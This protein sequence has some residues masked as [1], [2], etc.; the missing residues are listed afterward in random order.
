VRLQVIEPA[1]E[2]ILVDRLI[3]EQM[4]SAARRYQS[5]AMRSSSTARRTVPHRAPPPASPRRRVPFRPE[6]AARTVPRAPSRATVPAPRARR[7]I[8]ASALDANALQAYRH[9]EMS[10]AVVEQPAL[11]QGRRSDGMPAP[12]PQMRPCSMVR[13][14][15]RSSAHPRLRP[16]ASC[17]M[18]D[19]RCVA[20]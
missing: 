17:S 14:T 3:G 9:R 12:A 1:I 16:P 13:K 19:G 8:D 20:R 11:V 5:S 15:G 10:A 18:R 6:A 7:Q 2:P 4:H